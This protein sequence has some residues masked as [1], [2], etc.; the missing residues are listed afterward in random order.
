M[1]LRLQSCNRGGCGGSPAIS[2]GDAWALLFVVD[3]LFPWSAAGSNVPPHH[4]HQTWGA[5]GLAEDL[6]GHWVEA[7]LLGSG[8]TSGVQPDFGACDS[9]SCYR[10]FWTHQDSRKHHGVFRDFLLGPF[11]IEVFIN[12]TIPSELKRWNHAEASR[13]VCQEKG[14]Y[15]KISSILI[16][17]F[18]F[19]LCRFNWH[20]PDRGI[21]PDMRSLCQHK[22][23][24]HQDC[25]QQPTSFLMLRLQK[26]SA[27]I[28]LHARLKHICCIVA[29]T[30]PI[31]WASG[32]VK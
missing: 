25:E 2:P 29:P 24:N 1:Q 19:A 6:G 28:F 8:R 10:A 23:S 4:S 30:W 31:I 21:K 26:M 32:E 18:L 27:P 11:L 13:N 22:M 20:I 15:N 17:I 16:S 9:S 5:S 14:I 7:S 12:I 3:S